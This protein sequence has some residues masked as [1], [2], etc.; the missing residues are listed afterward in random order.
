MQFHRHHCKWGQCL[1]LSELSCCLLKSHHK[2]RW[3]VGLENS[4]VSSSY[5]RYCNV[6]HDWWQI[7]CK[8][9]SMAFFLWWRWLWG[10]S[11]ANTNSLSFSYYTQKGSV[12]HYTHFFGRYTTWDIDFWQHFWW[13]RRAYLQTAP[14]EKVASHPGDTTLY[15][16]SITPSGSTLTKESQLL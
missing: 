11:L 15:T 8:R 10:T 13:G 14:F 7:P 4:Q 12:F 5:I 6:L 16:Y 3:S 2:Q 1:L 9:L